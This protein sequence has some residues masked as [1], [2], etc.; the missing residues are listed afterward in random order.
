MGSA[1]PQR[2][3]RIA[4]GDRVRELRLSRGISQEQLA[5]LA[6][7]DRTYVS[8]VERGHR[9]IGIDNVYKLADALGVPVSDLF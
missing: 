7:L 2:D 8:G 1:A 5:H 9:N 4:L 3:H 6:G